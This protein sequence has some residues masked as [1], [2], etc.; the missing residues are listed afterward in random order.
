MLGFKFVSSKSLDYLKAQN[1]IANEKLRDKE[2]EINTLKAKNVTETKRGDRFEVELHLY[3]KDLAKVN[4]LHLKMNEKY[5]AQIIALKN[6]HSKELEKPLNRWEEG[7]AK[8]KTLE[9]E[10]ASSD[11]EVGALRAEVEI[12]RETIVQTDAPL[13]QEIMSLVRASFDWNQAVAVLGKLW[14]RYNVGEA[15]PRDSM[16]LKNYNIPLHEVG[17]SVTPLMVLERANIELVGQVLE[18]NPVQLLKIR[19][20]G[21]KSARELYSKLDQMNL[22]SEKDKARM[23]KSNREHKSLKYQRDFNEIFHS[24]S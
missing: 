23:L 1:R 6:L 15:T 19:N 17:L 18:L 12:Y 4:S 21:E 22:L 2:A 20:F 5:E 3:D 9:A 16:L 13:F 24:R 7:V 11:G 14:Q 8:I 10:L